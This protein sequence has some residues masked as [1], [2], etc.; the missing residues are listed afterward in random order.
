[1]A[2]KI[3]HSHWEVLVDFMEKHPD[4]ARG[5]FSGPNGKQEMKKLWQQ[6][7]NILNAIGM[8]ER[9]TEKWQKTWC[10]LKYT[11]KKRASQIHKDQKGT[12]GGPSSARNLTPFELRILD[13]LGNTFHQGVGSKEYGARISL[14]LLTIK[15]CFIS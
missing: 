6:L 1:M 12:G 2:F 8:G 9:S 10:D 13:V 14:E 5:S 4:L 15:K 3:N 11:I 7:S